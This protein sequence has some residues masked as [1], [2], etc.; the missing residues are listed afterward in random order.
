MN[1]EN[2]LKI[3]ASAC[4]PTGTP[5]YL[6]RETLLCA[7]GYHRFP[8]ELTHPQIAVFGRDLAPLVRNVFP[9]LP[10]E[11]KLDTTHLGRGNRKLLFCQNDQPV[12]ELCILYG[13]EDPVQIAPFKAAVSKA[14]QKVGSAEAWHKLFSL[15]PPYR[16]LFNKYITGR[17]LRLS[18]EAFH[19]LLALTGAPASETAFYWDS[20]TNKSPSELP[21]ELFTGSLFLT[22]EGTDYPVFSGYKEYLTLIFGDYEVGL[23]DE[24]GCGLTAADTDALI[25]HQARSLEALAFLQEVSQEYGLRYYLLAGSVLGCVRHQGF[26]P[27]DD[28]ID[29][30]IRVEELEHYEQIIREQLPKRLPKGFT[31]MQ[32]GSN[33]PY[34]RMFSKICY[35]GRCCIDLWP[36]VPTY[37]NGFRAEFLWYFAKLITKA[38]YEHIGHSVTKFR[39]LVKILNRILSDKAVMALARH[40]ERKYVRRNTPAYINLYSIYRRNKETIQ[41]QWLD[42]EATATFCGLEVPVVGCTEEYLTHLY[43]DYMAKPAPWKRASRH[44]A[45]FFPTEPHT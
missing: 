9:C 26:I 36:L 24:I 16:I 40:N 17:L 20:P 25:A 12:L 3:W 13:L 6:F 29:V 42:T 22:V 32:S 2:A 1:A 27:W 4:A 8:E 45:R 34:P 35:E 43:G 33:N 18:D 15:I 39:K 37:N 10:Q 21:C 38:H 5:W 11:W 44:S 19:N 7:V 23:Q 31:L 14:V 30:G 28:D 41:R